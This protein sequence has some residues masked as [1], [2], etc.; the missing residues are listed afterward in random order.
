MFSLFWSRMT[1]SGAIAGIVVGSAVV[2]AWPLFASFGGWFKVY[3]MVPG[4]TSSSLAI[5]IFSLL[6]SKPQNQY[7]RI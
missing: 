1:K 5:V 6:A 3:A 2:L 7:K 4:F